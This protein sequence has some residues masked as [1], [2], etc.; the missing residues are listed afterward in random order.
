MSSKTLG[1]ALLLGLDRAF[2]IN[3]VTESIDNTAEQLNTDWDVD[4]FRVS[5]RL[6][7]KI[8]GS[9][10]NLTGTLDSLAFLDKTIRTKKH[11]TD[12]SCFQ[13]HAH[14]LDTG[15]ES[16][17]IMSIPPC[18]EKWRKTYSTSS[19]AWTLLIP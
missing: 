7:L 15:S 2:S 12:L 3:R 1:T 9:T 19:S 5:P 17:H 14:S 13:V 4:L 18:A 6:Q 11:N 8:D 10:Y 16:V